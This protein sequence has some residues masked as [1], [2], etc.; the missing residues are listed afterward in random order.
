MKK[1]ENPVKEQKTYNAQKD[2][3]QVM[4]CVFGRMDEWTRAAH[5]SNADTITALQAEN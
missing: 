4:A 3:V 1:V 2:G 5:H